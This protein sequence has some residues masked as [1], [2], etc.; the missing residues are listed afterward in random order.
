M[1]LARQA[2][3]KGG[4]HPVVLNAADEEAVKN[5]LAGLIQ[6]SDIPKIIGKVLAHH[7][8]TKEKEPSI[9]D[10]LNAAKWAREE[11]RALCYR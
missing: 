6:F 4:T 3:I 9:G 8:D 2:L 7:K 1:R 10:I 11:A 5:Y